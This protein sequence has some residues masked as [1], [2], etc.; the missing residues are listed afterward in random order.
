MYHKLKHNLTLLLALL[1]ATGLYSCKDEDV[2]PN[3][4]GELATLSIQF[5]NIAG[6]RNLQLETGTYTNAAGE[7]FSVST[8]Q[9]FI[10]NI[11]VRNSSGEEYT[12]PQDSSYFLVRESDPASQF[13]KVKVPEG[14]YSAI[15]FTVGVDSLRSTSDISQRKGVLDPGAGM[16]DGMYWGW[17]SGYIFFKM[18]GI[19]P[20]APLD[21]TGQHRFRYHIG[22]FGGYSAPTI[23]N[24]KTI[25]LD[26]SQAGVARVRPERQSNIHILVDILKAFDGPNTVSIASNPTV[27]FSEF[28]VRLADN[29]SNMFRHDHTEN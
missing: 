15:T 25:T 1:L 12:V 10:S 29:Y 22:G 23:N 26:L 7:Q 18:E 17:N 19:S 3:T 5:D 6:E 27:M 13:L 16:D 11:K 9:Y 4:S 21:P 20:A 28:S 8:L 2:K 14:D 24:L